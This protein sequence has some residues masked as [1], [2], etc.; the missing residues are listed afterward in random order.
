MADKQGREGHSARLNPAVHGH[1]KRHLSENE[2]RKREAEMRFV[3][4]SAVRALR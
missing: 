3:M 4:P 1:G 2:S